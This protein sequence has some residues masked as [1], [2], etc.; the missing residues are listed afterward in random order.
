MA[1]QH[2]GE[3]IQGDRAANVVFEVEEKGGLQKLGLESYAQ[4]AVILLKLLNVL[5]VLSVVCSQGAI[6]VEATNFDS[7]SVYK[8]RYI[9]ERFYSSIARLQKGIFC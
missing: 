5:Q 6:F 3:L 4:M 7:Y 1:A 8:L 2:V 9:Y